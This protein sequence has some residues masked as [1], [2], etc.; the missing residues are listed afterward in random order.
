MNTVFE[1]HTV[2]PE[3]GKGESP[4]MPKLVN[5]I[6]PLLFIVLISAHLRAQDVAAITGVVTDQTGAVVP[7]A[8][9]TLE[10]T[11][12]GVTAKTVSNGIGSYTINEMKPGP[13][14]K[15]TF[16]HQGFKPLAIS[17]IYMNVDAT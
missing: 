8:T 4:L 14:Y 15:I 6:L 9:V 5:K 11:L 16:M 17:G 1:L 2:L 3:L 12:T 7:G 13:G 10:N